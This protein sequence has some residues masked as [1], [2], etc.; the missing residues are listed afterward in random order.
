MLLTGVVEGGDDGGGCIYFG[1]QRFLLSD[2]D[3]EERRAAG[4]S[5]SKTSESS[6]SFLSPTL[7]YVLHI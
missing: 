1:E 7:D 3:V 4:V 5:R 6:P 2:F